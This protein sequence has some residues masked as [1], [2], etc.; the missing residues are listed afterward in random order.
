MPVIKQ[1]EK[2]DTLVIACTGIGNK[3]NVSVEDFFRASGLGLVSKIILIDSTTR[4]V[5]G[6]IQPEFASFAALVEYLKEE[7][8]N[9]SPQNLIITGNSGGAHTAILLGHLLKAN[10]V[11]CFAPY[12][13]LSKEDFVRLG[14]PALK[15]MI[16]VMTRL[17]TLPDD[18]KKYFDLKQ[19]LANWNDVTEYFIHVSKYHD[20][21]HKRAMYLNESPKVLIVKHPYK[22]HAIVAP[23]AR[24]D[25]LKQCFQFPYINFDNKDY[26]QS[27]IKF[28]F[29]QYFKKVL[30]GLKKYLIKTIG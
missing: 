14:D 12:P 16:R 15:S 26:Y 8:L 1:L 22:T 13:Y 21:D 7:I 27:H 2:S 3:L 4:L 17:E 29:K 18:V 5:L 19:V 10:K 28:L 9:I 24:E 25:K 20:W 11:V 30:Q 6:G 23:L